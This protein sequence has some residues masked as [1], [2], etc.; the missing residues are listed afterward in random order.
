MERFLEL[1]GRRSHSVLLLVA[2]FLHAMNGLLRNEADF[3][4]FS[5]EQFTSF[6][7][8]KVKTL[9]RCATNLHIPARSIL[10][11]ESKVKL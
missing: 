5:N 8:L 3:R 4:S 2:F 6:D 9:K 1:T 7:W 10:E 11:N